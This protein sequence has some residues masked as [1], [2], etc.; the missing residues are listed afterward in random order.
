MI[1]LSESSQNKTARRD[2][3]SDQFMVGS[4]LVREELARLVVLVKIVKLVRPAVKNVLGFLCGIVVQR[5]GLAHI[6]QRLMPV[7]GRQ[8]I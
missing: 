2:Q 4:F 5:N 8:G 3:F 6:Q 1:P 7:Y